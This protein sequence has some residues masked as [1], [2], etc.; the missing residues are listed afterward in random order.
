M[1]ETDH[2]LLRRFTENGS[3]EAFAAIVERHVGLVH[4]VALRH[5][6]NPHHAEEI[7]QSVF[8]VLARK[9]GSLSG[10]VVL[11]GW[12]YHMARLMA[13]NFVRAEMR[14]S[15]REREALMESPAEEPVLETIWQELS[16]FLDDAM[17][18][19]RPVDRDA[20]VLRYFE[21]KS[22]SEVG[23]ALGVRERAAQKRV[24]RALEK[25]R[26]LFA[27]RGILT[28]VSILAAELSAHSIQAAPVGLAPKIAATI[29]AGS[30]VA[31]STLTLMKGTLRVMNWLKTKVPVCLVGGALVA[32]GVYATISHHAR[33][34]ARQNEAQAMQEKLAAEQAERAERVMREQQSQSAKP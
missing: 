32:V 26:S 1:S 21:K 18:H 23:T 31:G 27:S 22:L 17:A 20:L 4:S 12:L 15:E 24:D 14:R 33:L 29:A 2:E 3:D 5:T 34:Q 9:A 11:A 16:P 7:S 25:L 8:V 10:K 6:S 13:A 28:T 19:L 30:A